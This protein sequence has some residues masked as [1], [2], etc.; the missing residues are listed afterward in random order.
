MEWLEGEPEGTLVV[1]SA[2]PEVLGEPDPLEVR[3]GRLVKAGDLL[4]VSFSVNEPLARS[5]G[6][7]LGGEEAEGPTAVDEE[8]RRHTYALAV[9]GRP[10]AWRQGE[11]VDDS[12]SC[13]TGGAGG[14]RGWAVVVALVLWARRRAEGLR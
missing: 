2:P 6:V 3:P 14:T 5:P 11:C 7:W 4:E 1:D 12:C 10:L 13:R 8:A 9:A